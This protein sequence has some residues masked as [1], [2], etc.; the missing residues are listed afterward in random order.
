MWAWVLSLQHMWQPRGQPAPGAGPSRRCTPAPPTSRGLPWRMRALV[1]PVLKSHLIPVIS[2][3]DSQD[4][5]GCCLFVQELGLQ[6]PASSG[7]SPAPQSLALPTPRPL[8]CPSPAVL[9]L[10]SYFTVPLLWHSTPVPPLQPNVT[11]SSSSTTPVQAVVEED[12]CVLSSLT[13]SLCLCSAEWSHCATWHFSTWA[14]AAPVR[15]VAA[16]RTPE[17]PHQLHILH[18]VL[19]SQPQST[20]LV[21]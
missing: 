18:P 7:Q 16:P 21:A 17:P 5:W 19:L 20:A 10:T 15:T 12:A 11:W 13:S 1:S 9:C 8:H 6:T 14:E 2:I 3:P 4:L